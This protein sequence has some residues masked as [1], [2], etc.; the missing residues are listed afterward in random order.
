MRGEG[1]KRTNLVGFHVSNELQ[2]LVWFLGLFSGD[3][4]DV[5]VVWKV[6][7]L[8]E[9]LSGLGRGV[10]LLSVCNKR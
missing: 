8:R 4:E 5:N 7:W 2:E 10:E 1:R 6:C 9:G 3:A